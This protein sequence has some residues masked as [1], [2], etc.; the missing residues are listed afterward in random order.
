MFWFGL[1][2]QGKEM[3]EGRVRWRIGRRGGGGMGKVEARDEDSVMLT[4]LTPFLLGSRGKKQRNQQFRHA[5]I[6]VHSEV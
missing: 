1:R 4:C 2:E 3:D 5:V 6:G